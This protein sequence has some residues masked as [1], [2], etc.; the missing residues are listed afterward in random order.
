MFEKINDNL[1]IIEERKILNNFVE[2]APME[3]GSAESLLAWQKRALLACSYS[4]SLW[5]Y[6]LAKKLQA[7]L[8]Q[9]DKKTK[10]SYDSVLVWLYYASFSS[11]DIGDLVDMFQNRNFTVIFVDD[12]QND[13]IGKLKDKLAGFS[14]EERDKVRERIYNAI[15][16]NEKILTKNFVS[17]ENKGNMGSWLRHYDGDMG[18]GLAESIKLAEFV[19]KSSLDAKLS[20][21][22]K[23]ILKK[24]FEFYE[25]LKIS[26]YDPTGFEE[27]IFYTDDKGVA[28]ILS[29]GKDINLEKNDEELRPLFPKNLIN[30]ILKRGAGNTKKI[31]TSNNA[32]M[33]D[34]S[35]VLS[36]SKK[37]LSETGGDNNLI[38]QKL[39]SHINSKSVVQV[40][41]GILLLAQLRK[42]ESLLLLPD[43][44]NMISRDL[45]NQGQDDKLDELKLNPS[46][47]QNAARLLKVVLQDKLNLSEEDS[48]SFVSRLSQIL[49]IENEK[50][51]NLVKKNQDGI[52]KWNL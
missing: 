1:D 5:A 35:E 47:P 26:S 48:L 50:Y 51:S 10:D 52:L 22:E 31:A 12:I 6:K 15:H 33:P 43:A 2:G 38:L 36:E 44:S 49:L 9:A 23:I 16:K 18:I 20:S 11:L 27:D 7:I 39:I 42:F 41:A 25:Y 8:V 46:S 4:K 37:Y 19:N 28:H 13:L 24:F 34:N 29:G 21:E 45:R 32:K 3:V 14:I 17:P 30:K 40:L